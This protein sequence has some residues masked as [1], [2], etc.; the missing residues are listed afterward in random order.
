MFRYR[1]QHEG[2]Q[3]R[4]RVQEDDHNEKKSAESRR[5]HGQTAPAER[6]GRFL[7]K[8]PGDDKGACN[9]EESAAKHDDRRG[10]IPKDGIIAKAAEFGA[11][12]GHGGYELI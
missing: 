6:C 4:K 9:G 3:E 1:A 12:T 8:P 11:I 2:R 5:V 10:K 7:P